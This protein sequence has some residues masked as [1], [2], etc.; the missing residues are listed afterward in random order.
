MPT[1]AANGLH[2][3]YAVEGA[4]PPLVLLHGATSSGHEDFAAQLPLFRQAF[5]CIVP[6]AR[7]HAGTRWDASDGFSYD[8]LVD[9]L[10]AFA[11]GLGLASFHLLGF[12]MGGAT[13]LG[14]A[15]RR[16][17]RLRTL[18]VVGISPEREPRA[19][20]ARRLFD[21]DRIDR[22]DPAWAAELER[23]HGP[24]Q[25]AGAW[26]RLLPAIARDVASQGLPGPAD[27]V[28]VDAPTLVVVGDRDPFVPVGHA[29]ALRRQL[30]DAR[31][32]VAPDCGHE[33]GARRPA[34]FNEALAGFYRSTQAVATR[35]A[36]AWAASGPEMG[37]PPSAARVSRAGSGTWT[38][39]LGDA[40]T[41]ADPDTDWIKEA[42]R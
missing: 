7:G 42:A 9:D 34:L 2:I 14:F 39:S 28:R 8:R 1:L 29:W 10:E 12:S 26:R 31:L 17:G 3:A 30:P 41:T 20:V 15:S 19:S 36:E 4:G 35:R 5:R 38:S 37:V 24:V 21:P 22:H 16:P 18:V 23:R 32:F 13:A 11:D 6:E 25:G 33:V 27:L 40:G